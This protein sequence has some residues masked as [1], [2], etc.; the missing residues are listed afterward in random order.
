MEDGWGRRGWKIEQIAFKVVEHEIVN[1][2]WT[3]PPPHPSPPLSPPPSLPSPSC[4]VLQLCHWVLH[5]LSPCSHIILLCSTRLWKLIPGIGRRRDNEHPPVKM[6]DMGIVCTASC[7][8]FPWAV[9]LP[10]SQT[11]P[12]REESTGDHNQQQSHTRELAS[13][14]GCIDTAIF[15][16]PSPLPSVYLDR[17]WLHMI[18]PFLHIAN[19]ALNETVFFEAH[20]SFILHW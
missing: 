2:V 14:F 17:H 9:L 11:L 5:A 20:S 3:L 8:V 10:V 6:I 15:S 1:M 13:Y 7:W 12:S 16:T 19:V 18:I 4:L